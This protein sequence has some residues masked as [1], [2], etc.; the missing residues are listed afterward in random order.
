MIHWF[1]ISVVLVEGKIDQYN[2]IE[3]SYLTL[4][5]QGKLIIYIL[6]IGPWNTLFLCYIC[7]T[8][9]FYSGMILL[10]YLGWHWTWNPTDSTSWVVEITNV[11]HCTSV[12]NWFFSKVQTTIMFEQLHINERG[13]NLS[14]IPN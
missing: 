2:R 14:L 6:S 10:N 5:K 1:Y 7:I 4:D 9:F 3:N 8:I 12:I 13:F 11:C